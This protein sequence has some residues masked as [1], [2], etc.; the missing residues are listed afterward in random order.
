MI[1][2]ATPFDMPALIEMMR[3]YVS[4]APMETL[5]DSSLHNQVHIESLLTGLMFGRGFILIDDQCRGF[6]A[7]IINSNVWCPSIM[8]LHELA[9]WVKPEYRGGAVGGRL[10]L[11]FDTMA[12]DLLDNGRV[13]IICSSILADS[14]KINYEKRG[15]RLMQKTYFKEL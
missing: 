8:E 10:W 9:W 4:E 15:W 7:A 11:E 1:R 6:I 3:G 14:P 2:E 12:Q 5:K 13:Q